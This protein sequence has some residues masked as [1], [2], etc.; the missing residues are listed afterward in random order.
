MSSWCGPT[1]N[2]GSGGSASGVL[3]LGERGEIIVDFYPY[4]IIDRP[5]PDLIVFENPFLLDEYQSFAEPAHV[6]VSTDGVADSDFVEFRCD[7]TKT[8]GTPHLE[9]WPY[10]GCAGVKPVYANVEG[11]C[12][13]P[14]N[15]EA[16]G[17][18]AFDLASIGVKRARFL[19]LRDAGVSPLGR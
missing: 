14:W 8:R 1:G 7:T 11:N 4:E 3:S 13:L 19:R 18:D 16:A 6:A 5:G 10:P 9:E 17:G 2:G 15:S 12:L